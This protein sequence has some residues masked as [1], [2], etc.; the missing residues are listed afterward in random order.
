[1]QKNQVLRRVKNGFHAIISEWRNNE[2]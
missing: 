1:M 2:F